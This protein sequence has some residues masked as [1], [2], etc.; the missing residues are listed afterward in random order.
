MDNFKSI[1]ETVLDCTSRE[2]IEQVLS[3]ADNEEDRTALYIDYIIRSYIQELILRDISDCDEL[4]D[5]EFDD[6]SD[7]IGDID[8]SLAN[9]E[10]YDFFSQKISA[11]QIVI[12]EE[13]N[14]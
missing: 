9:D 2:L 13:E 1:E 10:L 6:L 14:D 4:S 5:D 8:F 7:A 11:K 12:M 3:E